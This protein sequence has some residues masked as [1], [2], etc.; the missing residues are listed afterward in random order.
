MWIFAFKTIVLHHFVILQC[1]V[2]TFIFKFPT[3]RPR[4]RKKRT[5]HSSEIS[6]GGNHGKLSAF[7]VE[8]PVM[9][10][11]SLAPSRSVRE[12]IQEVKMVQVFFFVFLLF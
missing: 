4:Y 7:P 11:P 10:V 5:S 9:L 12:T 1:F 6:V 8:A 3:A 2:L